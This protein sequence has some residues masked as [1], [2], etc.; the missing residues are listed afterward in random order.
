MLNGAM[1][2]PGDGTVSVRADGRV[3]IVTI[4]RPER[5]NAVDF[6][7]ARAL[8]DIFMRF[9]ADPN[10]DAAV[11]T[12]AG[13]S[14]CAGADLK[15]IAEGETRPIEPTASSGRWARRGSSSGSP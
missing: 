9:D 3:T 2:E 7:T 4:D 1:R 11:L 12:G 13:G 15:A 10:A 6:P 14:F 8:F 5:R